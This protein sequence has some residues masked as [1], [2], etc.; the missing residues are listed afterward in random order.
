[1]SESHG[2]RVVCVGDSNLDVIAFLKA[3]PQRSRDRYLSSA[4]PSLGGSAAN[5]AVG[6]VRLNVPSLLISRVGSDLFG[7]FLLKELRDEGVGTKHVQ[8]DPH[9][10]TG[11]VVALV[12][13]N[14]ERVL[15]SFRGANVK[16]S[17]EE[18]ESGSLSDVTIFHLSGY[19]FLEDPQRTSSLKL[20]DLARRFGS[21]V[22]VD[23]GP[24]LVGINA[25]DLAQII[26]RANVLFLSADEAL[27]LYHT[28]SWIDSIRQLLKEGPNTV[29]LKGGERGCYVGRGKARLHVQP[30]HVK[31]VDTTGAGDAFNSG[32][33]WGI[34]SDWTLE[35]T[36][37][38]ANAVAALKITRAGAV[39]GLPTKK[40]LIRFLKNKQAS[41]L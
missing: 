35:R 23:L 11:F 7:E 19:S 20:M 10:N 26:K 3:E 32:F 24:E 40:E 4:E 16:L 39:D 25:Q 1:M 21:R 27:R 29:A 34:L 30:F 6:L 12:S 18:V 38:T 28:S 17:Y 9:T 22:S 14:G 33:L 13:K 36:A 31:T 37:T 5:V 41:E 8:V 2:K 15:Y